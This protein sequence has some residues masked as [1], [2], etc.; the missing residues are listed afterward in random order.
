MSTDHWP[1]E[2]FVFHPRTI[3]TYMQ[4]QEKRAVFFKGTWKKYTKMGLILTMGKSS[5]FL[6]NT[7]VRVCRVQTKILRLDITIITELEGN[8]THVLYNGLIYLSTNGAILLHRGVLLPNFISK[9][10]FISYMYLFICKPTKTAFKKL[11]PSEQFAF[12]AALGTPF[13]KL[14]VPS[15]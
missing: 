9:S 11:W 4:I 2:Y 13:F 7:N 6:Q 8:F 1:F 3:K 15:L 10:Q 14:D 12:T 5:V